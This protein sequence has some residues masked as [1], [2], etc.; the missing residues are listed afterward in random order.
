MGLS[1][2]CPRAVTRGPHTW[3][4]AGRDTSSP[5]QEQRRGSGLAPIP[6][7]A[8]PQYAPAAPHSLSPLPPAGPAQR[9]SMV[10]A[11]QSA[12]LSSPH[13][14]LLSSGPARRRSAGS[15][16][17]RKCGRNHRE[18]RGA[19][20]RSATPGGRCGGEGRRVGVSRGGGGVR[21]GRALWGTGRRAGG[22]GL[23]GWAVR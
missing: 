14:L 22:V 16:R 10:P 17:K 12:T 2:T 7:P 13:R 20:R 19:A 21:W 5:A 1:T 23:Y 9:I 11:A 15:R 4:A 18:R 8:A 3:P 6:R